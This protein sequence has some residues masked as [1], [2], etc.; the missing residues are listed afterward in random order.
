MHFQKEKTYFFE[1]RAYQNWNLG[2]GTAVSRRPSAD[3]PSAHRPMAH[4]PSADGPS[5]HRPM[6]HRP[7]AHR[8][9]AYRPMAHRTMAQGQYIALKMHIKKTSFYHKTFFTTEAQKTKIEDLNSGIYITFYIEHESWRLSGPREALIAVIANHFFWKKWKIWACRK[10]QKTENYH[11]F[12]N[13][14]PASQEGFCGS[15]TP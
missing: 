8:P 1:I 13:D 9:M 5:A 2:G 4:R 7:M 6:A 14:F 10:S 15:K 12:V 11:F 3:G